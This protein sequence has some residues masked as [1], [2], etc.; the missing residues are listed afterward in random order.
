MPR[1]S[2]GTPNPGLSRGASTDS[3]AARDNAASRRR[4]TRRRRR[5]ASKGGKAME[6][7]MVN[8]GMKY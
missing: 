2:G 6:E 5:K 4:T 7:L 1:G 3:S 8:K